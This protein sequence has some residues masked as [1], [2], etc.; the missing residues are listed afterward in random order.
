MSTARRATGKSLV[1]R[2]TWSFHEYF[3]A[4]PLGSGGAIG[5]NDRDLPGPLATG[6][7]IHPEPDCAPGR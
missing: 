4:K 7:E 2:T 1:F 5:P 6:F 3:F